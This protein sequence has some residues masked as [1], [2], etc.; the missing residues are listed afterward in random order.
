MRSSCRRLRSPC[1]R[2]QRT[3]V[4]FLSSCEIPGIGALPKLNPEML[5]RQIQWLVEEGDWAQQGDK[6]SLGGQL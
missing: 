2:S 1:K 6:V 4:G 5:Y 3:L